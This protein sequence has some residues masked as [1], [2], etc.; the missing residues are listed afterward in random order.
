MPAG[1]KKARA[2]DLEIATNMVRYID[3]ESRFT[4][5]KIVMLASNP[6]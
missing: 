5:K 1:M 3:L 2:R 4:L 6:L